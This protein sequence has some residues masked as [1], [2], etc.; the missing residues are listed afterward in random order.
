MVPKRKNIP[1]NAPIRHA[2]GLHNMMLPFFAG[3][4]RGGRGGRGMSSS[5]Q[6]VALMAG[7]MSMAAMMGSGNSMS[8]RGRGSFRGAARGGRGGQSRPGD[9]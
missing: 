2:P 3:G 6:Q 4:S 9:S 5:S 7:L 1:G 8:H